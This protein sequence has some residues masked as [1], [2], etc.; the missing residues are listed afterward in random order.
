MKLN[1]FF[2]KQNKPLKKKTSF[3]LSNVAKEE[4]LQNKIN[5]LTQQLEHKK[6]VESKNDELKQKADHAFKEQ[7]K[8][9]NSVA[10]LEE[11]KDKS[12]LEFEDIRPKAQ[13]LPQVQKTLLETEERALAAVK[14]LNEIKLAKKTQEKNI[15]FLSKERVDFQR[16]Y[17]NEV[18]KTKITLEELH[19]TQNTLT[20]FQKKYVQLESFVDKLSKINIEQKKTLEQLEIETSYYEQEATGAKE[21]MAQLESRRDEVLDLLNIVNAKGSKQD[22]KEKFLSNQITKAEA[23]IVILEKEY[24]DLKQ[25]AEYIASL[26]RTYKLELDKPRYES[27]SSI[28]RKEGFTIPGIASAKNYT[29]LHLGNAKPTLLKFK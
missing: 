18:K 27:L 26:A 28:S 7:K 9:L 16:D 4:E 15:E 6:N 25:E 5:L 2:E 17:L 29:K 3:T 11:Y 1:S 8:A 23:R 14:D 22:S 13:L 21:Y 10:D 20:D 12:E 24:N 19:K